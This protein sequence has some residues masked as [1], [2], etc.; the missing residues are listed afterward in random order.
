MLFLL[1]AAFS[2]V[3]QACGSFPTEIGTRISIPQS[4]SDPSTNLKIL[5]IILELIW[6]MDNRGNAWDGSQIRASLL[7]S[8]SLIKLNASAYASKRNDPNALIMRIQSALEV[9][10]TA[11]DALPSRHRVVLAKVLQVSGF[12]P[13]VLQPLQIEFD[14]YFTPQESGFLDLNRSVRRAAVIGRVRSWFHEARLKKPK[15]AMLLVLDKVLTYTHE[16]FTKW[17]TTGERKSAA[18]A[19]TGE[20]QA[21]YDFS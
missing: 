7:D 2:E 6:Q 11:E 16:M 19:A 18:Q 12:A 20:Q 4:R 13:W 1:S 5:N 14:K 8:L 17:D 15:T 21:Q 10:K 3:M 9:A